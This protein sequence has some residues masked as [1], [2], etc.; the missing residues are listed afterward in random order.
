MPVNTP[1]PEEDLRTLGWV[2]MQ[3][4]STNMT[5]ILPIQQQL[6]ISPTFQTALGNMLKLSNLDRLESGL[7]NIAAGMKSPADIVDLTHF[8]VVPRTV[9]SATLLKYRAGTGRR[10]P[11]LL[12]IM[13]GAAGSFDVGERLNLLPSLKDYMTKGEYSKVR[14]ALLSEHLS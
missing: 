12:L 8:F 7:L 3:V 14:A 13:Y 1:M 2:T 6:F 4:A 9:V 10:K 5:F 11:G